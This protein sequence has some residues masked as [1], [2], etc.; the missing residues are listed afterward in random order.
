MSSRQY[1][2]KGACGA[3]THDDRRVAKRQAKHAGR[4][5]ATRWCLNAFPA[6]K[7]SLA[8]CRFPYVSVAAS[9]T[10]GGRPNNAR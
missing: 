5:A 9:G 3:V 6:A 7:A 10:R 4:M 1:I 8:S 2:S